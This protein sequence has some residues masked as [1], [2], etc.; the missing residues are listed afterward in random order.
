MLSD[1]VW[2]MLSEVA[3]RGIYPTHSAKLGIYRLPVDIIGQSEVNGIISELKTQGYVLDTYADRIFVTFKWIEKGFDIYTNTEQSAELNVTVEI[4]IGEVLD[5]IYQIKPLETFGDFYWI[6]N[7]RQK[8]DHNAKIIIDNI[9]RNTKIGQKLITYYQK[10]Q[11]LSH[12]DSIKKLESITPLAN[13]Q[14]NLREEKKPLVNQPT[15]ITAG[16]PSGESLT[17]DQAV[18]IPSPVPASKTAK[19]SENTTIQL[20]GTGTDHQA[21]DG[22]IDT[23]FKSKRQSVGKYQGI[24]VWGPYDAPGQL[25]IWG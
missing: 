3:K 19:L 20:T 12:D 13:A 23:G 6:R 7:Y 5:I 21:A 22:P 18:A 10:I 4:V 25:G 16:K 15:T 8:A 11:K 9:I 24:Q 17:Q 14:K 2:V 1:K